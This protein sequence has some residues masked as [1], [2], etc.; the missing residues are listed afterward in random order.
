MLF[1]HTYQNNWWLFLSEQSSF[2]IKWLCNIEFYYV[3][4]LCFRHIWKWYISFSSISNMMIVSTNTLSLIQLNNWSSSWEG[5]ISLLTWLWCYLTG[6]FSYL[7]DYATG[8][9]NYKFDLNDIWEM[10]PVVA[11]TYFIPW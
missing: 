11:I 8:E 1:R 3:C 7:I 2:L 10:C 4:I 9:T 5:V 6:T